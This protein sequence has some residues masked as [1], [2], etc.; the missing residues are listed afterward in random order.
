MLYEVQV[1]DIPHGHAR[2]EQ[3]RLKDPSRG[4]RDRVLWSSTLQICR[5]YIADCYCSCCFFLQ[6]NFEYHYAYFL[7]LFPYWYQ[8]GV[9]SYPDYFMSR[10]ELN[11]VTEFYRSVPHNWRLGL[12]LR[13]LDRLLG[14]S[15]LEHVSESNVD[16]L[17]QSRSQ[18]CEVLLNCNEFKLEF[19]AFQRCFFKVVK[20]YAPN[21]I[22]P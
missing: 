16:Q 21:E 11:Y 19:H 22:P 10:L 1:G 12:F 15:W 9:L 4:I 18:A 13:K 20:T 14:S 5:K 3:L 2:K 8:Y 7:T 6:G 17:L